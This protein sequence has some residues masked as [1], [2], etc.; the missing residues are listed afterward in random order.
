MFS[1]KKELL[2]DG[3]CYLKGPPQKVWKA[4]AAYVPSHAGTIAVQRDEVVHFLGPA[5]GANGK[6]WTKVRTGAGAEGFVPTSFLAPSA[7]PPQLLIG[8]LQLSK[9]DLVFEGEHGGL[10]G[11]VIK[12][13]IPAVVS[14]AIDRGAPDIARGSGSLKTLKVVFHEKGIGKGE[15]REIDLLLTEEL[16]SQ[17]Q[18]MIPEVQKT[19]QEEKE[20]KVDWKDQLKMS[21]ARA[22][23]NVAGSVYE[24]KEKLDQSSVGTALKNLGVDE[25]ERIEGPIKSFEV[26][27]R[28]ESMG[29]DA[30]TILSS[31]YMPE[32][33][34][35]Q[36]KVQLDS[37]R[38]RTYFNDDLRQAVVML[39]GPENVKIKSLSKSAATDDI[40]LG[41]EDA[42]VSIDAEMLNFA[43]VDGWTTANIRLREISSAKVDTK[44]FFR[45]KTP[46]GVEEEFKSLMICSTSADLQL[47]VTVERGQ[48][49]CRAIDEGKRGGGKVKAANPAVAPDSAT[50]ASAALEADLLAGFATTNVPPA[51]TGG[52]GGSGWGSGN[53]MGIPLGWPTDSAVTSESPQTESAGRSDS[54]GWAS[55]DAAALAIPEGWGAAVAQAM[56]TGEEGASVPKLEQAGGCS[57]GW[58]STAVP[59]D[60]PPTAASVATASGDAAAESSSGGDG[61]GGWGADSMPIPAGWPPQ[62]VATAPAVAPAEEANL[63]GMFHATA[64]PQPEPAPELGVGPG[65]SSSVIPAPVATADGGDFDLLGAAAPPPPISGM[66][67]EGKD[68]MSGG[69]NL[70]SA[71]LDANAWS[72]DEPAA[73][74][75]L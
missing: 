7:G 41:L 57:D 72:M 1:K 21:A 73:A 45:Y 74:G 33:E 49:I 38:V 27:E 18:E 24:A 14:A 37:G 25:N 35:T 34:V 70:M 2:F 68:L 64:A 16:A 8:R 55:S 67:A 17:V 12:A 50:M 60:W 46:L 48:A 39:F 42:T 10:A 11:L 66:M 32:R 15:R 53:S 54:S 9:T 30:G 62:A 61:D 26:G 44:A 71:P 19:L 58:G 63:L 69:G 56:G 47:L 13:L 75:I 20:N 4:K 43:T 40:S 65:A 23:I 51:S 3:V 28:V 29:G 5:P 6:D 36:V 59:A 22:A 52:D 31:E